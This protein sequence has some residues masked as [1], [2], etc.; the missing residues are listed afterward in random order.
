MINLTIKRTTF[1]ARTFACAAFALCSTANAQIVINEF[2]YVQPGPDNA[3]FIE[4]YA[5]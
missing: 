2:D 3:E 5:T 1:A 4:L